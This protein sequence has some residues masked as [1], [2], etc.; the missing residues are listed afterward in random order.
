MCLYCSSV[1][2]P[3]FGFFR[4]LHSDLSVV[5]N[6][7]CLDLPSA[8]QVLVSHQSPGVS[9]L[10]SVPRKSLGSPPLPALPRATRVLVLPLLLAGFPPRN[11]LPPHLFPPVLAAL[12]ETSTYMARQPRARSFAHYLSELCPLL[13]IPRTPSGCYL[14]SS[15]ASSLPLP[16][17]SLDVLFF[18]LR[19]LSLLRLRRA[20]FLPHALVDSHA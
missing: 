20:L 10:H 3:R 6:G 7:L 1:P 15:L 17:C 14:V 11:W 5:L 4:P 19:S 13:L 12:G 18:S 2:L 16:S 9:P 8:R